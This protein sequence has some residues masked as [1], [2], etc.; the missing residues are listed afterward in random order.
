MIADVSAVTLQMK[1]IFRRHLYK[2]EAQDQFQ[3]VFFSFQRKINACNFLRL[4]FS[5]DFRYFLK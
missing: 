4:F 3:H 1:L 2:S 5:E